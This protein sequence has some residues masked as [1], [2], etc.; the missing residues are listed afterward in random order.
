MKDANA[1][2]AVQKLVFG[3]ALLLFLVVAYFGLKKYG[4]GSGR[5]AVTLKVQDLKPSPAAELPPLQGSGTMS[6]VSSVP[7]IRLSQTGSL[8]PHK[9]KVPAP[10]KD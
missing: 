1:R 3:I 4:E 5:Q 9:I 2:D 6:A 10:G 8:R 7:P